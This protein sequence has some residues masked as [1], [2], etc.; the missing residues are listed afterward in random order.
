MPNSIECEQS[1]GEKEKLYFGNMCCCVARLHPER[2]L[3]QQR[4]GR[5]KWRLLD[6]SL[7]APWDRLSQARATQSVKQG[8]SVTALI[9]G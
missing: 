7:S 8:P 4:Q 1:V 6:A 2:R 5:K 3:K 9:S